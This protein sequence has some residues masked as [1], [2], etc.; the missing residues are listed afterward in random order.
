M[1]KW[2]ILLCVML[3]S[4]AALAKPVVYDVSPLQRDDA[5]FALDGSRGDST[6][7]LFEDLMPG[8]NWEH[9]AQYRLVDK[10]GK[11][12][13]LIPATRPPKELRSFPQIDGDDFSLGDRVEF[14]LNDFK[15]ELKV[16]EPGRFYAVLINGQAD[17]RHWND[18]AFL[19]RVLT[20]LYGYSKTQIFVADSAFKDRQ[21]DLDGDG[22]ADILYASSLE[23]VRG[24]MKL[25][26]DRV[27]KEDQLL[28]AVNDHGG[29]LEGESTIVLA[30]GDMKATEFSALMAKVPSLKV[31]SIF[32]QCFSGGFVRPTVTGERV[33]MAAATN[34]EYSWASMDLNF[35]E[36][37][38]G[39]IA[40]FAKQTHDGRAV[41]ANTDADPRIS[42]QEAFAYAASR[43][44]RPESPLLE[45]S[46]NAGAARR[47][48]VGF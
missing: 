44:A 34:L 15:G 43:D 12:L 47:M 39:V 48:G 24:L 7:L 31:L 14:K 22:E 21:P 37:I 26:A 41:E 23:G 1:Q 45:S 5:R 46:T 35:D 10:R 16:K 40:A 4:T 27:K 33:S 19:F 25:V 9:P 36:F 2:L 29:T 32:E 8:A 38:Y 17:Q 3:G 42:A 30:D 28:L 18:F 6:R 11:T 20:Q 13:K